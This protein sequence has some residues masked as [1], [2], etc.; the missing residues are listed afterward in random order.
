MYANRTWYFTVYYD[1]VWMGE[2]WNLYEKVK[3]FDVGN[4]W[5]NGEVLKKLWFNMKKLNKNKK[6]ALNIFN[7]FL[8][9]IYYDIIYKK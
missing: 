5:G 6:N 9:Y 7:Y 3:L 8:I 2:H 1:K 4:I